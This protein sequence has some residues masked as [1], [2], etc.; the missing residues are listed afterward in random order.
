LIKNSPEGTDAFDME[1]IHQGLAFVIDNDEENPGETKRKN[2]AIEDKKGGEAWLSILF[3]WPIEP[4][5]LREG[6]KWNGAVTG[7]KENREKESS[8]EKISF[9][10]CLK[11]LDKKVEPYHSQKHQQ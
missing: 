9:L 8:K 2:E 7:M 6:D 3:G 1:W 10:C 4:E 5:N 11:V